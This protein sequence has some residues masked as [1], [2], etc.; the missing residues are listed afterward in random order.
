[1]KLGASTLA[2]RR[3]PLVEALAHLRRLGFDTVDLGCIYPSYCPH[4]DPTAAG[5]GAL[6]RVEDALAGLRVATLTIG[7]APWNNP[8]RIIRTAQIEFAIGSLRVARALGAYAVTVQSGTKPKRAAEWD[9]AAQPAAEAIRFVMRRAEPLGVR[10]SA[11]IQSNALVET[12]EQA[13]QLLA[14]I[15]HPLVG[16]TVDTSHLV[17]L[18]SDPAAVIERLGNRV[19]HVH[20]RDAKPG[21]YRLTPGDGAVQFAAVAGA[22]R[23]TGYDRACVIE[24]EGELSPA[25]ADEQLRRARGHI[26]QAFAP[27]EKPGAWHDAS[28]R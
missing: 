24:L 13:E 4:F 15:N 12:V 22:L 20:L 10:L 9:S 28:R 11:E 18:G 5:S 16:V 6:T 23:K 3:L 17:A 19:R 14:L 27:P 7:M 1:M 2:Y 26:E 21:N 25:E 8:D